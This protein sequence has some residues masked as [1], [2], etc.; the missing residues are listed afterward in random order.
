M[1]TFPLPWGTSSGSTR[2]PPGDRRSLWETLTAEGHPSD[3][4]LWSADASVALGDLVGGSSLGGRLDELRGRS[5]LVATRDQLTTALVL[6]ELDGIARRLVVCPPDVAIEH[7]ASVMGI[8]A[9]DAL[10]SDRASPP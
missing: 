3:L 6:I 1:S 2:M 5:V 10:V 8:A 9:I 7:V 4:F